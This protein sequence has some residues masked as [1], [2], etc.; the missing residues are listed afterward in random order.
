VRAGNERLTIDKNIERTYAGS[1]IY[2][3]IFS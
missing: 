2:K 1:N 3:S